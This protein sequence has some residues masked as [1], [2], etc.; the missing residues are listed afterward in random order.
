MYIRVAHVT[1]WPR[2]PRSSSCVLPRM[3]NPV[4]SNCVERNGGKDSN[5]AL[6][7][8]GAYLLGCFLLSPFPF[9]NAAIVGFAVS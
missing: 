8:W 4:A 1:P 2:A 3:A 7:L 9:L 5:V 6:L